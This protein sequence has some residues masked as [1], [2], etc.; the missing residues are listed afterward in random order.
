MDGS[1][2]AIHLGKKSKRYAEHVK[3]HVEHLLEAKQTGFPLDG[4]TARWVADLKEPLET[5]LARVGLIPRGSGPA[6]KLAAFIKGFRAGR[7]DVKPATQEIWQQTER[8]LID[9]F[10][11]DREL[12]SITEGDADDFKQYML[13][14]ELAPTTVQKRLQ[15]AKMFFRAALRKK[16]ITTNPFQEVKSKAAVDPDRQHF[17]TRADIERLLKGCNPNWKVIISLGRFGGLRCPS[18]VLSLRWRDIDWASGRITVRSPKTE[19][20]PGKEKR[21]IP[22]FPELRSV[23]LKAWEVSSRDA[24]YVVSGNYRKQS[25]TEKGWRNCNLRTQFERI[26]KRAGLKP[27]PRLFH[28]L[29]ASRE[30]ELAAQY[31]IHVV[32]AWLGNTP[33]IAMKHYLQVTDDD[34]DRATE[35]GRPVADAPIEKVESAPEN[36]LVALGLPNFSGFGEEFASCPL[37]SNVGLSPSCAGE[38]P[39]SF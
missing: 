8:N 23:L 5:K 14:R 24:E 34:F 19:H 7:K 17:V 28:A 16:L 32:T 13:A 10:G 20:H 39:I 6:E 38:R 22:L 18:E 21:T 15:F 33:K 11:S 37:R 9:F 3:L 25:D 29:R 26:I 12:P 36:A 1:R 35:T 4:E 30:T 27:W 31:P 2:K